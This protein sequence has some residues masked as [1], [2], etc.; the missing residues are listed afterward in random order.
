LIQRQSS[1]VIGTYASPSIDLE[2]YCQKTELYIKD[3]H[4]LPTVQK[5]KRNKPITQSDLDVLKGR[6]LDVSGMSD[7]E[8][9]RK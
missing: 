1:N 9:Y 3:H 6:L 7:L 5:L 4:D 2:Q 8:D